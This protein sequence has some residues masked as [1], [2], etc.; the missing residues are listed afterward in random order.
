MASATTPILRLQAKSSPIPLGL[1]AFAYSLPPAQIQLE[2]VHSLPKEAN[3]ANCQVEI[4]GCAHFPC[5][6]L[7]ARLELIPSQRARA[8][9]KSV[10]GTVD[11]FKA[12]G[13]AFAAQGALGKDNKES[14]EVSCRIWR[15]FVPPS[16][17][18]TGC[19]KCVALEWMLTIHS[20]R[21]SCR[22]SCSHRLSLPHS[23]PQ[24]HSSPPSSNVSRSAPTSPALRT[25]LSPT[26]TSG[27][28]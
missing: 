13:D 23:R 2:W 7:L 14:T 16:S 27:R 21:R 12:L 10:F 5:L 1:C 11:C 24:L 15:A 25:R 8:R 26:I 28:L 6:V 18:C 20:A 19:A 22:F 17:T 4:N 9:S 3:G